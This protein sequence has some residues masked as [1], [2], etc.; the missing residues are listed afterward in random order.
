MQATKNELERL[1]V[2]ETQATEN[3]KRMSRMQA[4]EIEK[5]LSGTQAT[6]IKKDSDEIE[7]RLSR[8]QATEFLKAKFKNEFEFLKAEQQAQQTQQVLA[9]Y[10]QQQQKRQM[11][12]GSSSFA[13]N[14]QTPSVEEECP[15]AKERNSRTIVRRPSWRGSRS[16]MVSSRHFLR[17]STRRNFAGWNF[18]KQLT[19]ILSLYAAIFVL[20]GATALP[21]F[22]LDATASP[23]CLCAAFF[24]PVALGG[25]ALLSGP[26]PV[27]SCSSCFQFVP[28]GVAHLP[29]SGMPCASAYVGA[30]FNTCQFAPLSAS[31]QTP[32]Q[33]VFMG[34]PEFNRTGVQDVYDACLAVSY[35]GSLRLVPSYTDFHRNGIPFICLATD[36]CGASPD[37]HERFQPERD[38]RHFRQADVRVCAWISERTGCQRLQQ[39]VHP[40]TSSEPGSSSKHNDAEDA[41]AGFCGGPKQGNQQH[42]GQN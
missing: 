26:C 29:Y 13:S 30:E 9:K 24:M 17:I 36:H 4:T 6:E 33:Q 41:H 8:M 35:A 34:G 12:G 31:P 22:L 1:S 38:L 15:T 11:K 21:A 5:R 27:G 42:D 25:F 37:V 10:Q 28:R 16:P 7:K 3:E 19:A 14:Y 23:T 2:S 20:L 39:D 40:S 32:A 18:V